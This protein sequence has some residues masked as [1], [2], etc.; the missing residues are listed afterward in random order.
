M[1]I[2]SYEADQWSSDNSEATGVKGFSVSEH[3]QAL[4]SL[5]SPKMAAQ[6]FEWL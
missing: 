1:S 3:Y 6:M 5:W 4:C 2:Y